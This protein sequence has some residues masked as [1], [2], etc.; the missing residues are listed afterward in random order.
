[1]HSFGD[2]TLNNNTSFFFSVLRRDFDT[3]PYSQQIELGKQ[4]QLR[5]HPPK[6]S[7]PPRVIA[8]LKNGVKIA[9]KNFIQSAT[10]NLLIIQARMEDSGNYTCVV[11]NDVL[12]RKS[13]VAVLTIYGKFQLDHS[14]K[15]PSQTRLSILLLP[16]RVENK[17]K[18]CHK[19]EYLRLKLVWFS[20]W[21]CS[22]VW[23]AW[24]A[25]QL[26]FLILEHC[27]LPTAWPG[28]RNVVVPDWEMKCHT[29]SIVLA[30][31]LKRFAQTEHSTTLYQSLITVMKECGS[32]WGLHDDR[33]NCAINFLADLFD[34][35]I[36]FVFVE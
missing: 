9:D 31:C 10:G 4:A 14:H 15:L 1:M 26:F 20:K 17:K 21:T 19:N 23:S 30:K 35:Y 3:P 25:V 5:C 24:F 28:R 6:G 33:L 29:L 8:W 7:P 16:Q 34:L 27:V 22:G 18:M 36:T 12:T 11:S 2:S 13:P 32:C